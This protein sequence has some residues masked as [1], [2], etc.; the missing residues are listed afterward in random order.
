[1]LT[2]EK[3]S[4]RKMAGNLA[5]KVTV[6]TGG[7]S[8]IGLASVELFVAQGARVVVGDIQDDLCVALQS[9]Y[10]NDV[11]YL[12]TDVTDDAAVPALGQASVYRL[13]KFDAVFRNAGTR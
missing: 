11:A 1:M 5:G 2:Q 9:P 3:E 13:G 8:G 4:R 7:A 12:R 6:I 10:P